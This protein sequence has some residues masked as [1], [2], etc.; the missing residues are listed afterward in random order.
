MIINQDG[1][2]N[3]WENNRFVYGLFTPS[4]CVNISV[5][6][7]NEYYGFTIEIFRVALPILFENGFQTHSQ[8]KRQY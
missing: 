7:Q 3:N 4:V 8:A 1:G 6:A 2:V 5:D